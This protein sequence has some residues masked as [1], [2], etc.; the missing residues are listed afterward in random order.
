MFIV[1]D[2]NVVISAVLN[3]GNLLNIFI[4]NFSEKVF[5]FIAP[6]FLILEVGK[7]TEKIAKKTKFSDD[8]VLEMLE[9]VCGQITFVPDEYF[10][11]NLEEARKILKEHEKD[12]PYLALALAFKCKIFSGDKVL[13]SIIPDR[14]KTPREL[15]DEFYT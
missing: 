10:K 1:V 15:L 8:E 3:R 12:V 14:I 2:S 5:N 7:H 9:F 6:N 11:D 13:K 4:K